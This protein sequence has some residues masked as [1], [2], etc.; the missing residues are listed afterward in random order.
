MH[1]DTLSLPLKPE[2]SCGSRGVLVIR[3]LEEATVSIK[4][5][6]DCHSRQTRDGLGPLEFAKQCPQFCKLLSPHQ[7]V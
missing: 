2:L 1:R 7:K 6:I 3:N 4:G 5:P